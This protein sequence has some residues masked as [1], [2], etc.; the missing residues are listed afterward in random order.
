MKGRSGKNRI[1]NDLLLIAALLLAAA[2]F[3][4]LV[5]ARDTGPGVAVVRVD[6][7]ETERHPLWED[8]VFPLNGGS[9]LLVIR[10]GQAWLSEANCP[11]KLCVDQGRISRRG[12]AIICLPNRLT[13]T[14]E[15]GAESEVD[16][17][18]R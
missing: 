9:N 6:G 18:V 16:G 14:I 7:V 15:G 3:Y 17:M 1:R 13:V 10:D 12:Q 5:S 4:C 11:D 2:V 8:G